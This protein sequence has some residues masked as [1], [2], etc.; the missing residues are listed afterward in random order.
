MS[1]LRMANVPTT[2]LDAKEAIIILM[3]LIFEAFDMVG[4]MKERLAH[5]IENLC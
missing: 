3:A 4:L 2:D 5:D 1:L